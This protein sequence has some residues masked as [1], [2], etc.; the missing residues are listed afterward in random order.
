MKK[1]HP[2]V[3]PQI[4]LVVLRILNM[5][6]VFWIFVPCLWSDQSEFMLLFLVFNLW[7]GT[8]FIFESC[9]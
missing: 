6:Y 2:Q 7:V 4:V 5:V 8:G 9:S 1:I 3:S